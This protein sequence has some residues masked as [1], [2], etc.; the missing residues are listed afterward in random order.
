MAFSHLC[1]FVWQEEMKDKGEPRRW[2]S[3]FPPKYVYLA[4]SHLCLRSKSN[5][6]SYNYIIELWYSLSLLIVLRDNNPFYLSFHT[7]AAIELP[8]WEVAIVKW[9]QNYVGDLSPLFLAGCSFLSVWKPNRKH[10][11]KLTEGRRE[12]FSPQACGKGAML[13]LSITAAILWWK[14]VP[15]GASCLR[16]APHL[17]LLAHVASCLNSACYLLEKKKSYTASQST[18]AAS[19]SR[20]RPQE[21]HRCCS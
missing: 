11:H 20:P 18:Q 7:A 16:P 2:V 19:L 14:Q 12:V 8:C 5:N 9:K 3:V 10:S 21:N 15:Q 13:W 1:S 17:L 6:G 4:N